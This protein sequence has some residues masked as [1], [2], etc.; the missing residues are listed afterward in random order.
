[1]GED[2]DDH[3]HSSEHGHPNDHSHDLDH[4]HDHGEAERDPNSDLDLEDRTRAIQSLLVEKGYLSVDAVDEMIHTHENVGPV[5]GAHVV[6]RSW[7][8]PEY[9]EWLLEDATAAVDEGFDFEIGDQ[10]LEFVENTPDRHNV[11]VC[12]LCSCYPWSLLGLPPT[13]Y[14][15]PAYRSRMPR[16]PR[17]VLREFGLELDAG[18]EVQVWD[19]NSELRY[20]VL[21][22]RPEGT[23][24]M[25]REELADL[26]TR[27][28]LV[29]VDRLVR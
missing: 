14:K 18:L 15:S 10:Y 13:W 22:Q 7:I 1:M 8:D 29:G 11:V 17:E 3:G 12:S 24:D 4:P 5:N 25:N 21:P 23:E 20:V 26:V 9:R 19:S 16:E 2:H 6:A 28:H 27:D